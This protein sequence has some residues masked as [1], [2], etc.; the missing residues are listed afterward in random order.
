MKHG[1]ILPPDLDIEQSTR[2]VAGRVRAGVRAWRNFLLIVA[3]PS[4]LFAAY[5][6]LIAAD[7]YETTSEFIVKSG[8]GLQASAGAVGDI[9]GFGGKSQSQTE[10]LSVPDYLE[11]HEVVALLQ[12][13][14]NI[15]GIF[16]RPEADLVTRLR[17]PKPTPE[18][19]LKYYRS[20]VNIRRDSDTGIMHMSVQ[21]YRPQDS[22]R[23]G[24]ALLELGELKINEMNQRSYEDA[25]KSA[26]QQLARAEEDAAALQRK[27]T[28]FRSAHEDINPELSGAAQIKLVSELNGRIANARAQ[29]GMMSG[30]ISPDSP[31]YQAL[32][33][34]V[35]ALESE[36]A[37]QS[38]KMGAKSAEITD[39]I[40]LYEELKVRQD[41]AS[42]N[43][44]AA[45]AGLERAVEAADKQQLYFV[46]V[47]D[48][49]MPVKS[50]FPRRET[51]VLT[52]FFFLTVAYGIGWLVLAGVREHEA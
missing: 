34:Q 20:M 27:I 43:Y 38:G 52:L 14:L 30:V 23:I 37:T 13:S 3:L 44:V 35:Q 10:V 7:R 16:R 15:V 39:A 21:T 19:L 12:K 18:E 25:I 40:G 4:C 9:L 5:Q 6:Y 29:L 11:S 32:A 1:V 36:V 33:K 51:A 41:F 28:A 22:Y 42:K 48:P 24:Q 46:R 49:N 50:L 26:R 45:A 8:D 31:Q 2:S 47:V 17:D